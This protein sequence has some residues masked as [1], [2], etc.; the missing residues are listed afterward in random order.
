MAFSIEERS[1]AAARSRLAIGVLVQ[2]Y[3]DGMVRTTPAVL[4]GD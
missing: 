1:S 2:T 3:A 4:R